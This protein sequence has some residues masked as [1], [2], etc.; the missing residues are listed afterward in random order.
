[1]AQTRPSIV[2]VVS[3][4]RAFACGTG[5]RSSPLRR[6]FLVLHGIL[7]ILLGGHPIPLRAACGAAAVPTAVMPRSSPAVILAIGDNLN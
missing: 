4:L 5:I 6:C 7:D 3:H 1:M 2:L